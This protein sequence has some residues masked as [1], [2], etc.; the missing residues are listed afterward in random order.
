MFDDGKR[1]QMIVCSATLHDLDV[2][3]LA[4]DLMYFP[5]W[6]D[7]KGE[8]SVP[9]TVHHVIVKVDPTTDLSWKALK[10][11]I[12]TDGV[13]KKDDLNFNQPNVETLSEAVKL[14][15]GKLKQLKYISCGTVVLETGFVIAGELVVAVINKFDMDQGIIFCRTKVD[16]DNLEKYLN[17]VGGGKF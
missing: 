10:R 8:D 1:L 15:K 3:R 16:C 6:V 11:R 4:E 2:K 5:A 7:L 14:I 9:E 13:H 12:Q 17:E